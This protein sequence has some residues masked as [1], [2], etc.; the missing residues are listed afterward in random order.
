M[1]SILTYVADRQSRHYQRAGT[2]HGD[3]TGTSSGTQN[4]PF[5]PRGPPASLG[6]SCH[7]GSFARRAACSASV[8]CPGAAQRAHHVTTEGVVL[9]LWLTKTPNCC[10][11]ALDPFTLICKG[12]LFCH[13]QF[14]SRS[15]FS[16]LSIAQ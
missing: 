16:G 11:I 2:S 9:W 12:A 10:A 3:T 6:Y 1:A 13:Y 4:V 7:P 14:G 15:N 5:Q 8:I